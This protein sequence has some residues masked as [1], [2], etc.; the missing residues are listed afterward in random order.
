MSVTQLVRDVVH[1]VST[2][3]RLPDLSVPRL[4]AD[5]EDLVL[6][7]EC[8]GEV[9]RAWSVP[10]GPVVDVMQLAER[11]GVVAARHPTATPKVAAFSVPFPERPVV[12]IRQ[13]GAKRDRDR[14]SLSHEI[15]HMAMHRADKILA[16]K[17]V[18]SQ[19]HRFAAAFLMPA[20]EIRGELPSKP[21]AA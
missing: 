16:P 13:Q 11:H 19:A 9:R 15:G 20:D 6:A 4:P 3:V 7:E 12:V 18:E 21:N 10:P 14:F 2:R 1:A 5:G 17:T 8:A